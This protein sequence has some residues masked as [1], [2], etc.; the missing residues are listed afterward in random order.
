MGWSPSCVTRNILQP[1][2]MVIAV[3][4]RG[5]GPCGP[6]ELDAHPFWLQLLYVKLLFFYSFTLAQISNILWKATITLKLRSVW[7][8]S[9]CCNYVLV[10]S[11]DRS[12]ILKYNSCKCPCCMDGSCFGM[13]VWHV[14]LHVSALL[15]CC[16]LVFFLQVA[17]RG[18][19][20]PN[21][22]HV[23]NFDMPTDIEEYVHRIGRTGRVGHTGTKLKNFCVLPFLL[24][25]T[26]HQRHEKTVVACH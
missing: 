4:G 14:V 10:T 12:W 13:T 1:P 9:V 2:S 11:I 22:R 25:T 23:I 7:L 21:V 3:R 20:I 18:L 17:A 15:R 16:H 5:R 19:D 24:L 8:W 6:S 26:C